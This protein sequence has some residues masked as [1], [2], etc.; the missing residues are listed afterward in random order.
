M[1]HVVEL[2]LIVRI[3]VVVAGRLAIDQM[4]WEAIDGVFE[5][6]SKA[7]T[8]LIVELVHRSRVGQRLGSVVQVFAALDNESTPIKPILLTSSS[9]I[10]EGL[11]SGSSIV[12]AIAAALRLL[13][14]KVEKKLAGLV[15]VFVCVV[16]V[17]ETH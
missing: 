4:E 10:D 15:D 1:T 14:A 16:D 7:T 13:E 11:A 6:H 2:E 5:G 12:D 3:R 8:W 17:G 9:T